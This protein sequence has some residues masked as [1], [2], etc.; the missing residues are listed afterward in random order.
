MS[1]RPLAMTVPPNVT[2]ASPVHPRSSGRVVDRQEP[3]GPFAGLSRWR[4]P[5]WANLDGIL[6]SRCSPIDM[7][8]PHRGW[9]GVGVR[10]SWSV[11]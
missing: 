2:G 8:L 10:V 6:A 4:A 1:P 11:F 9:V 3:S 5:Q 7:Q